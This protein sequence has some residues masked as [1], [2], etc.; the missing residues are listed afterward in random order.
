MT[1]E[2]LFDMFEKLSQEGFELKVETKN[3]K[4]Y[5][6]IVTNLPATKSENTTDYEKVTTSLTNKFRKRG[7]KI[8]TKGKKRYFTPYMTFIKAIRN[9]HPE[10]SNTNAKTVGKKFMKEY[11]DI[12][13]V[14][15]KEFNQIMSTVNFKYYI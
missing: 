7:R 13:K 10:L 2:V 3:N 11:D 4:R 1:Q 8:K 15:K 5:I 9:K 14:S 6:S 12:L